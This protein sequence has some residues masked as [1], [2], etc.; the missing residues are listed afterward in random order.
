MTLFQAQ[1]YET[2]RKAFEMLLTHDTFE[3]AILKLFRFLQKHI[4][5]SMD[6]RLKDVK[7]LEQIFVSFPQSN[8]P[9]TNC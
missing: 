6:K 9:Y 4:W 7:I 3:A 1:G 5:I 8:V 2:I